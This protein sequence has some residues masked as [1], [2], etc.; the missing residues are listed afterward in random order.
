MA[1]GLSIAMT[2]VPGKPVAIMTLKGEDPTLPSLCLNS[3]VDVV[4]V[5]E[6]RLSLWAGASVC[7]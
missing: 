2:G 1:V 7:L 5:D 3:H 6:V 4:P